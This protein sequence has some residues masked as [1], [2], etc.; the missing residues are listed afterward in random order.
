MV[1][2]RSSGRRWTQV[3]GYTMTVLIS[4]LRDAVPEGLQDRSF[5]PRRS[6]CIFF[7]GRQKQPLRGTEG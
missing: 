3:L 5:E 4:H 1:F 6:A 7:W 2:P